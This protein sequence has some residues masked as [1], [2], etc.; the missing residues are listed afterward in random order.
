MKRSINKR[1][2]RWLPC[3]MLVSLF[4]PALPA[5]A[6][7][8]CWVLREV[9][10]D[11]HGDVY[12]KVYKTL[13]Y[14]EYGNVRIHSSSPLATVDVASTA[15]PMPN[16]LRPG[17]TVT[18]DFDFDIQ[19]DVSERTT[20][21]LQISS[22]MSHKSMSEGFDL[23]ECRDNRDALIEG[24][25]TIEFW[26]ALSDDVS[27]INRGYVMAGV[28]DVTE[29]GVVAVGT[30][31]FR[32]GSQLNSG[33]VPEGQEGQLLYIGVYYV[34][35]DLTPARLGVPLVREEYLYTW[36]TPTHQEVVVGAG[37]ESGETGESIDSNIIKP[38]SQNGKPDDGSEWTGG[39]RGNDD[40]NLAGTIGKV[41]G[42]AAGAA[43]GIKVI[44]GLA[45]KTVKSGGKKKKKKKGGDE[46]DPDDE[47]QDEQKEDEQKRYEKSAVSEY[48]L[49]GSVN[50]TR[51]GKEIF[52]RQEVTK[53]SKSEK[54][55]CDSGG[56]STHVSS[57]GETHGGSSGKF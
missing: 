41:G 2:L 50:V 54:E 13:T 51:R 14:K 7:E 6:E 12:Q 52:L 23:Q 19:A 38:G 42:A 3:L 31:I 56:S 22:T 27:K 53:M 11:T 28:G 47:P 35:K 46:P 17:D 48:V 32:K 39:N 9:L 49:Q 44:K 33:T 25:E 20:D 55:S 10:V 24:T 8:E 43:I 15:S 5:H 18:I 26:D 21:Y 40:G 37:S 57:S 34:T 36:A 29:D 30:E 4:V 16:S 45:G 1:L